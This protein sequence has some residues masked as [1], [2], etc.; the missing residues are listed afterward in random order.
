MFPSLLYTRSRQAVPPLLR[1]D[2]SVYPA[3]LSTPRSLW[4]S[5][6]FSSLYLSLSLSPSTGAPGGSRPPLGADTLGIHDRTPGASGFLNILFTRHPPRFFLPDFLS[7]RGRAASPLSLLSLHLAC[8]FFMS[9]LRLSIDASS[10]APVLTRLSL[11][12][13]ALPSFM[14]PSYIVR[15]LL[16]LFTL[17]RANLSWL[18][19]LLTAIERPRA[20]F[21]SPSVV[22]FFVEI[23]N[24]HMHARTHT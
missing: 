3:E 24:A 17:N 12:S 4:A 13:I 5:D 8:C 7:P 11:T 21:R 10:S 22:V 15:P 19:R 1:L 18:E 20:H 6:Q 9:R 14:P 23:A 16:P 2:R